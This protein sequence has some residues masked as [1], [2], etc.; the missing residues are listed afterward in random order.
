MQSS[1]L[2]RLAVIIDSGWPLKVAMV[3]L[4]IM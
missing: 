1:G 3:A 2:H 4:L